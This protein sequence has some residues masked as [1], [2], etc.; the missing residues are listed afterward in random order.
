MG[1]DVGHNSREGRRRGNKKKKVNV[2]KKEAH[3]RM[4]RHDDFGSVQSLGKGVR[5]P[6]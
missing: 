5:A 6:T 4:S 2:G 3:A 1:H